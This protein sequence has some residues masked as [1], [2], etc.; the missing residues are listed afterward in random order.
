M[1]NVILIL[2]VAALFF[3]CKKSAKGPACEGVICD[4]SHTFYF[5]L[6]DKTTQKNLVFGTDATID[7]KNVSMWYYNAMVELGTANANNSKGYYMLNMAYSLMMSAMPMKLDVKFKKANSTDTTVISI[8]PVSEPVG[9]C[10]QVV[11]GVYL[12]NST[13]LTKANKTDYVIDIPVE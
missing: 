5:R 9:C 10:G 11:T 12:N 4:Y 2:T 6:V 13:T 7:K 1:R 3:S 8:R